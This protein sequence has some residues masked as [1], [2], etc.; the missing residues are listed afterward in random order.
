MLPRALLDSAEAKDE[1]FLK[2]WLHLSSYKESKEGRKER[3]LLKQGR[4]NQIDEQI[5]Y[6]K[7][8]KE[9]IIVSSVVGTLS[10]A[11]MM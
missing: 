7:K 5:L 6:N 9:K 3:K 1:S 4:D 11:E 8:C 10:C 2:Q